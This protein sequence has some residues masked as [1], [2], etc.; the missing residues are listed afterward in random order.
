MNEDTMA[1]KER[2]AVQALQAGLEGGKVGARLTNIE[3]IEQFRLVDGMADISY[4]PQLISLHSIKTEMVNAG[5]V[6]A[7]PGKSKGILGRFIDRLAESNKKNYGSAAL[8]CCN[9][10]NKKTGSSPSRK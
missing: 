10:N 3:G 7:Q 4:N 2:I 1:V 6:L 9:L 5:L 8:D